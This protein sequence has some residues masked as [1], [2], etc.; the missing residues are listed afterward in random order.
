MTA[1]YLENLKTSNV[2]DANERSSVVDAAVEGL[3][4][5]SYNPLE[6]SLVDGL[7]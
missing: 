7:G 1:A 2:E 6:H 4:D 3:V 5:A